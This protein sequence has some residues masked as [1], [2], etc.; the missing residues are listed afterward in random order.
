MIAE[1]IRPRSNETR[2]KKGKKQNKRVH[3]F[4]L[5]GAVKIKK[6]TKSIS[7]STT[8]TRPHTHTHRPM[9]GTNCRINST[10]IR[11]RKVAA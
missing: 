3:F 9:S 4:H 11:R 1:I 2:E 8:H 6:Q 5:N 10:D 7:S